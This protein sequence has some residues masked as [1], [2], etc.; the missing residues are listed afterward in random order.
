MNKHQNRNNRG[1]SLVELLVVVAILTVVGGAIAG[2]IATSTHSYK[3]VSNEVDLQ[4]EAQI[5]TNQLKTLLLNAQAGV[6]FSENNIYIYNSESRYVITWKADEQKLYYKEEARKVDVASG[7]YTTEFEEIEEDGSL[8][9]EYVD[10]FLATVDTSGQN[11]VVNLTLHL[12]KGDRTY[13]ASENVTLRNS[14]LLNED[15][16]TIYQGDATVT[17]AT[18]SGIKVRLGTQ[19]FSTGT[20][21]AYDVFL[22]DGNDVTIPLSVTILGDGFPSQE[23]TCT[24]ADG[25]GNGSEDGSTAGASSV[26]ISGSERASSLTLTVASKVRPSICCSVTI[27]IRRVTGVS[28]VLENGTTEKSFRAGT[29]L[30]LGTDLVASVTGN[31]LSDDDKNVTWSVSSGAEYCAI[32]GNVLKFSDNASSGKTFSV[33]ATSVSDPSISATYT[34]TIASRSATLYLTSDDTT[35]NRG[36]SI[37]I[38]AKESESATTTYGAE[39]VSW[40]V[41]VSGGGNSNAVE[42]DEDGWLTVYNTADKRLAYGSEYTITVTATLK[43]ATNVS[44]TWTVT[45]PKVSVQYA[46]TV[47]GT[48]SDSYIV[49]LVNVT[50]GS[51]ITVYY[52]V[53]GVVSNSTLTYRWTNGNDY[54]T[55]FGG[56]VTIGTNSITIEKSPFYDIWGNKFDSYWLTGTPSLDGEKYEASTLT[57]NNSSY[58][59]NVYFDNRSYYIPVTETGG[60]VNIENTSYKYQVTHDNW[61]ISAYYLEIYDEKNQKTYRFK[62]SKQYGGQTDWGNYYY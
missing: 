34:G 59:T 29:S 20:K 1:F 50:T 8:F 10:A 44:K 11:I 56:L 42:I 23:Y 53:T 13:Q 52:R 40:S 27:N 54:T 14:I 7:S 57:V 28:I 41:S 3:N 15:V 2:F 18:Y 26:V 38:K 47:N 51:S 9:A 39:D 36:G 62:A 17:T 37:Q 60:W 31:G 24:F 5:A 32:I 55:S 48:Y 30:T 6:N 4:E 22:T 43:D 25:D 21:G 61:D 12:T 58:V 16:D 45:V 19:D 49:P 35:V 33:T 46:P